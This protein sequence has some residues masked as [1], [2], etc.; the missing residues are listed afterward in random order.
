MA[1]IDPK[2][3][4]FVTRGSLKVLMGAMGEAIKTEVADPMKA[5]LDALEKRITALEQRT[6]DAH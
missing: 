2:D 1:E 3:N 6:T 4:Q 5:R